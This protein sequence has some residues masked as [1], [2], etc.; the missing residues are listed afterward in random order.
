MFTGYL[1]WQ[2]LFF[3]SPSF[4]ICAGGNSLYAIFFLSPFQKTILPQNL[5]TKQPTFKQQSNP[6]LQTPEQTD[7]RDSTIQQTN[8]QTQ[9]KRKEILTHTPRPVH[10][11]R[12]EKRKEKKRALAPRNPSLH[13]LIMTPF[14]NLRTRQRKNPLDKNQKT[15]IRHPAYRPRNPKRETQKSTG[16]SSCSYKFSQYFSPRPFPT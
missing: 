7:T 2:F 16:A 5:F 15:C 8:K 4:G 9:R 12:K 6:H 1:P 11:P 13:V 10:Q 3:Q 14:Q